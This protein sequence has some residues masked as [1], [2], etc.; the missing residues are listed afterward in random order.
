VPGVHWP[1]VIGTHDA[2]VL[3]LLFQTEVRSGC[4]PRHCANDKNVKW[5]HCSITRVATVPSIVTVAPATWPLARHSAAD[6]RGSANAIRASAYQHAH[7]KTFDIATGC[8][9]AEPTTVR[10]TALTQ[11]F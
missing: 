6:P 2:A 5:V 7:S 10:R 9:T 8:S 11:L 4:Q 1:A 3:A